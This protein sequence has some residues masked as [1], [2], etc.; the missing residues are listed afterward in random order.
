MVSIVFV[1]YT[2]IDIVIVNIGLVCCRCERY[3]DLLNIGLSGSQ[4]FMDVRNWHLRP[5]CVC[6]VMCVT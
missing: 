3:I 6:Q 4:L 2:Y 5:L 1:H